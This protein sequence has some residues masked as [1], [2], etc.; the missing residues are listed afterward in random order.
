MGWFAWLL[1]CIFWLLV[2]IGIVYLVR[3]VSTREK[4]ALGEDG[5]PVPRESKRHWLS[6]KKDH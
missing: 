1:L 5:Q 4:I 6:R 2:I 3:A